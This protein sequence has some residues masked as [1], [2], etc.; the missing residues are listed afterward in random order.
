MITFILCIAFLIF[1]YTVYGR[2]VDSIF[3]PDDRKTP[4]VEINDGVDCVPMATWKAFLVQ[5]LNIR[6]RAWR[7]GTRLYVGHD[8]RKTRR[9]LHCRAFGHISG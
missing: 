5:L 9:Q 2:F 1:G 8:I 3:A 4:A 7:C 6:F